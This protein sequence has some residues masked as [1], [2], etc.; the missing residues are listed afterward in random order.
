VAI[1]SAIQEVI[2]RLEG[3]PKQQISGPNAAVVEGLLKAGSARP[4]VQAAQRRNV[5]EYRERDEKH[6]DKGEA[7]FPAL[8]P[9]DFLL[10]RRK[11]MS[12]G[13]W[14]SEYQQHP[15]I[16]GGGAIPIEKLRVAK[17][18]DK[19]NIRSSVRY[20]DK[21]GS[22]D[23]GAYTACVLMHRMHDNTFVISHIARGQW[24]A[25]E[26]PKQQISGPND[27]PVQVQFHTIEEVRLF[28]LERGIDSLRVPP[29]P[30]R[31]THDKGHPVVLS[32]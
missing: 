14:E 11:V 26:R 30:L 24:G 4:G 29:P 5:Y 9:L 32:R 31:L 20:I 28:L 7:L 2:N 19:P 3:R 1:L 15:I 23:S 21:A 6:R 17:F 12:I 13:S 27:G 8:K 10:A 18:F 22:E 25:L 16:V